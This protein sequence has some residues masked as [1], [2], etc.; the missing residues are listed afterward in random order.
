M[1][2]GGDLM[3]DLLFYDVEVFHSNAFVVFKDI[4]KNIKAVFHNN[5]VG[6]DDFI[7]GKTLVGYNNYWYDDH[8]LHAMLDLRMPQQIKA[9]SDRAIGG[10]RLYIPYYKFDSLDTFQQIDP[11][12]PSLKKIEANMGKM[13][14]ESSVPFTIER[15]L[16]EAEYL[17][18]LNYCKYD[19]D[20]TIEVYKMREKNYFVP[21]E[22][23]VKMLKNPYAARWNT[24]TL[25]ANVLVKKPVVKWFDIN[26]PDEILDLVPPE[27][28]EMWLTKDKGSIT[29]HD[30][31]NE[32]VFGFGG[33]HGQNTKKKRFENVIN[34]DVASLYPS[35]IVNHKILGTATKKY[36]EILDE[37]IRIKHT[38]PDKQAG[39][40]LILNSVYGLLKSEY[41]LLNN[42][43]ASTTVCAI[44]QAILYD[45]SKRLSSTCEIVQ[46]NTDGVAFIPFTD[47]YKTIWKEWENDYNLTL[48][49]E[50]FSTFW[51]RD[52]NNYIALTPD[53]KLKTKGGDVNRYHE[54]AVFKNN[55][56]RI[57]DKAII[58]KLVYGKDVLTT[59]QEHLDEPKLY[60]YIL[61]AGRTYLGTYDN[62][63]QKHER[64]NRVF[65]AKK[66]DFCLYKKRL[67]GG[68]VRFADAPMKMFL[69]ND[70]CDKI[71]NFKKIVDL[72]H[73]YQIIMKKLERW[74]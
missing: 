35:I 54:D 49:R 21:K 16:T 72:N 10:E 40:K 24:T 25:S 26:V 31:D 12:M 56:A 51:Q 28:R 41:S 69:W 36:K 47:D 33:L 55:N 74:M 59:L 27:V 65:A 17:D 7:K 61:Q 71:E 1:G 15:E 68:M 38:D 57:I 39:L 43:K 20:M 34:L 2:D 48:E 6:L 11:N 8:I 50:D 42:P 37:R 32:I 45:L 13:I 70:D 64:I 3:K 22:S 5:F 60:Q 52:V 18:V 9:L 30:F 4:D 19:V 23:I 58:N 46:I 66:G 53:G 73:Y 29:I 67:D 14:L 63:D 62:N 44:G